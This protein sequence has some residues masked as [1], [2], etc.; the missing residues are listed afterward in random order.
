MTSPTAAASTTPQGWWNRNRFLRR[1]F[2]RS[3]P[4]DLLQGA[5]I[6]VAV[7]LLLTYILGFLAVRHT[8]VKAN[9]WSAPMSC[10]IPGGLALEAG[11][12]RA[13][14][15]I[16]PPHEAIYWT[17]ATDRTGASLDGTKTYILHFPAGETPPVKAFWSITTGSAKTRLMVANPEHKYSVS[18]HSHLQTNA[19]GSTDIY[20]GPTAPAGHQANWLPTPNGDVMLWLRMYEPTKSAL[21]GGWT[22]PAIKEIK[23]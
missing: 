22:P 23:P 1:A 15:A 13:Y 4:K 6:G 11:C 3:I 8:S 20:L 12:A 5:L 21:D 14:P 7:A 10:G 9:G 2:K 16:N 17:S 19:D 18:S